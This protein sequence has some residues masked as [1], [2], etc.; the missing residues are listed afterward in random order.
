MSNPWDH[1]GQ[2]A[3]GG[4]EEL[5]YVARRVLEEDLLSAGSG[6]DV[7]AEWDAGVPEPVH[8]GGEVAHD[9]V[10]PVPPARPGSAPSGIGDRLNSAVR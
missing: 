5:D 7:V 3:V 4:L 6:D 2:S 9:Q 8:L 10:D 1:R